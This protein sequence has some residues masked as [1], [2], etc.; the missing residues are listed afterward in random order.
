MYLFILVLPFFSFFISILFGRFL[1]RLY[2]SYFTTFSILLCNL[3]SY[4]IFYEVC[5]LK[6][7]VSIVTIPWITLY[8]ISVFYSFVFDPLCSV[9]LI[10][11]SS[12]SLAAHF[13]SIEYMSEDP[14]QVRFMSYLSLFTFFMIILVSAA[15]F[16]QLFIGWEGV[17]ICSYLLINFWYTRIQANQAAIK[18]LLINKISDLGLMLGFV[19]IFYY[20][21][22]LDFEIIK[23]LLFINDLS[24][25]YL[26]IIT[27]LLFLGAM[28]KSAQIG[29][30]MWLPDA[31]EGPTPVSSLIH[32]ATMVTA[33][34]FLVLRCSFL[35]E[36]TPFIL[37]VMLI[38]GSLTSFFAAS[39]GLFQN[40][41]KKVVAYSTCS[42]LGYM[43]V[44]CSVSGYS[45]AMFHLSNHAFFKALLF[46]TAGYIIHSCVHEQDMRKLGGLYK[47]L[48]FSYSMI[49]IGSFSLIG[50]P[51]LTGFYSKDVILEYLY[52]SSN[53]NINM[54]VTGIYWSSLLSL[55]GTTLYSLKVLYLTFLGT[56]NGFKSYVYSIHY[57]SY[58]MIIPL[59][60]LSLYS[61]FIG[62]LTRDLMIGIGTDFWQDSIFF[63]FN[64]LNIYSEFLPFYVKC[65]PLFFSTYFIFFSLFLFNTFQC[66]YYIYLFKINLASIYIFFNQKWFFDKLANQWLSVPL[67]TFGY[68]IAFSLLD[69]GIIE[70]LGP[71]GISSFV[72]RLLNLNRYTQTGYLY[73][74]SGLFLICVLIFFFYFLFKL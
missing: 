62:Y 6:S 40:D 20:F 53:L 60:I 9:M 73:H 27:L 47:I 58:F 16:L 55:I 65:A 56:F 61:I 51:F 72:T 74:Y 71:Y 26:T 37:L 48:P 19:L 42:Q 38:L 25:N 14:H 50:I 15:N 29:L 3:L 67:L 43:F 39:T 49:L 46:L 45:I 52:L 44:C 54:L 70:I 69:K 4:F 12:I 34:V 31:M 64:S 21:S 66:L 36:F 5:L 57:S 24:I 11:I 22:S 30:H 63:S 68:N 28:G 18:A 23:S 33:G 10:V 7:T 17:G 1:G 41:I 59:F 32:A 35:F 13:Y 8:N 2:S